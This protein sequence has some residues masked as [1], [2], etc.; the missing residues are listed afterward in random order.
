MPD[1][2]LRINT[3]QREFDTYR[4]RK[5]KYIIHKTSRENISCQTRKTI[6]YNFAVIHDLTDQVKDPKV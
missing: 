4:N 5:C 2:H 3:F 1:V 6:F